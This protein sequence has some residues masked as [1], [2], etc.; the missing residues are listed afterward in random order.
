MAVSEAF[1]E[2]G[3]VVAA[4]DAAAHA[5][6]AYRRVDARGSAFGASTRATTLAERCGAE[7]PA[8]RAA[9]TE[10]LP[11]SDR[12]REILM[13]LGDGLSSRAVAER[14]HLST[15]TVENHVYRAMNKTGTAS[16][17]EL[18]ALLSRRSMT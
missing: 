16:R 17:D 9:V 15:R 11:L 12:E 2:M 14:L 5:A 18:V 10:R 7:T 6:I 8:L 13:L 3:D 1:E 4:A